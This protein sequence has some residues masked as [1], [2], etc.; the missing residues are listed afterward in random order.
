MYKSFIAH[1]FSG[2]MR[3]TRISYTYATTRDYMESRWTIEL[4][5]GVGCYRER[6]GF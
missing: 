2:D 5:M 3:L 1:E 4:F 6:E